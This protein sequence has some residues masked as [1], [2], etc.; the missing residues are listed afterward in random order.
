MA[1]PNHKNAPMPKTPHYVSKAIENAS[2]PIYRRHEALNLADQG[3]KA[4][5]IAA[6]L[7]VTRQAVEQMIKKA[8]TERENNPA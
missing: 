1:I 6:R 2:E 8:R 7:G 5:A 4:A 3:M